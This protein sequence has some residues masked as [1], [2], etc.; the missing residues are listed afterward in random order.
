MKAS[1]APS[2]VLVCL[3][4]SAAGG[5]AA[6][7]KLTEAGLSQIRALEQEKQARTPAQRKIETRLLFALY[8][9]RSDARI[10]AVPHLRT[11]AP[12][13]D[14]RML[15]DIDLT[16]PGGFKGVI[17]QL[18][19]IG[20]AIVSHSARFKSIRA[21]VPLGQAEALAEMKEVR[22]IGIARQPLLEKVD[23]SEGDV[24]HRA[25]AARA[26][27]GVD[28]AGQKVCVLSDGVDSLGVVQASGDLPAVDV[29]P[30]QAGSGD[31]GTAMLEIVHDLAPG[32]S[33]G[34]ATAFTSA[35]QFAQNILDLRADGCNI[36]VDDVLYLDESPFQDNAIAAAVNSVTAAGALYFSSAGNEGNQDDGTAGTWE[37]NFSGNGSI[38]GV[39]GIAH[40][41]GDGGQSILVLGGSVTNTLHWTDPFGASANDYDLYIMDF[42]LTTVYDSST[43]VQNG[44]DDPFEITATGAF[45]FEQLVVVKHSGS[46]RMINLFA[47][48]GQLDPT[49][50]TNGATRGH[51]AAANAFSVAAVDAASAGGAGGVFNGSEP[52]ESFSSDGPRRIF[53]NSAGALLPGAPAGNFSASGGVVR[54][55]PDLA[56]ADGVSTATPG[57]NP[58]YGTSAAAPHAAAIAA[59]VRQAFPAFTPAQ[60][61]AALQG[62]ALDIEAPGTDR[63]SGAGIV[64]AYETLA[65]NGAA[66]GANLTILSVGTTPASGDG[67][68]FV[69]PGEA[70]GITVSL[71]NQGG[72]SATALSATLSTTTPGVT[73]TQASSPY[74][75]LAPGASAA[76]TTPFAFSLSPS[77]T[78][79]TVIQF[80][81]TVAYSGGFS[82]P[83]FLDFSV[84]TGQPG[85]QVAFSYSGS[86]VAIPDGLGPEI[87]GPPGVIPLAVSGLA[88]KLRDVNF[89]IDGS[90]C[91]TTPGATSVGVDHTWVDD[92]FFELESPFG[93]TTTL[94]NR[95]GADGNNFCQTLLDDESAGPS[96][97]GLPSS[98]APFTGS[99]MPAAPLAGFRGEAGNGTWRLRVTDY[100]EGDTG[101]V[102]AF[103]LRVTPLVCDVATAVPAISISDASVTEADTSNVNA[104][105]TVSLSAPS[106]QTVTVSYATAANTAKSPDFVAKALTVL[107]FTPGQTSKPVTIAVKGDLKDEDTET[108]F[109]T[110]SAPTNA[111]IADAQGVGT[112]LD[113]DPLPQL[114]IG[115]VS[116]TEADSTTVAAKLKV[117]LT[118]VSGRSVSFSF[119]T[120]PGTATATADYKTKSGTLTINAGSSSK[121]ISVTVKG[122][123][124]DEPNETFFVN[125]SSPVNA[126]ISDAQGVGTIVD[127]DP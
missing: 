20:A 119:A 107:T 24:A 8:K 53:F 69:E 1:I 34:F 46:N 114:S 23:T 73:V 59:L 94:I 87:P 127:D 48:R 74:P 123:L 62:S 52:V 13:A 72:A 11:V 84:E 124:L 76:N 103:S 3:F 65:D 92:L 86:S 25:A 110:L 122:D 120:A 18:R 98:S 45:P 102:R 113:N 89:R 101:S 108:F 47:P 85:S 79:G 50:T 10:A 4:A 7:R 40:N 27:F 99:F 68:A 44:N 70:F 78:C 57:F 60:I 88:G 17:R 121:T 75:N 21:R 90:S 36:L 29:L 63:D 83:A 16:A 22:R 42:D 91:T 38:T 49:L 19:A 118:P 125:L 39:P 31:E 26:F 61:R 81:L 35:A 97:Q 28:G 6:E 106:A 100:F 71:R 115:D 5:A 32:A 54:Q 117:T 95:T 15:L 9:Q 37:G 82:S 12:D 2:V 77:L 41:F 104:T 126:T 80:R 43:N 116:V 93:T 51:S 33:L 112:I 58:F 111:T 14:G 105:F 56:A 66:S 67:D 30:G 64:M 96:I 109:V 55:K